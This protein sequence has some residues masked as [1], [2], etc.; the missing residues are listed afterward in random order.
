MNK[1]MCDIEMQGGRE[2]VC[3]FVYT[4]RFFGK[5]ENV[6]IENDKRIEQKID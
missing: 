6:H 5:N 4:K 2:S 3:P 1:C